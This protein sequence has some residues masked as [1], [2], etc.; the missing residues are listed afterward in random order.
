VRNGE[1]GSVVTLLCDSGE[2]YRSTHLDD[3][4]MEQRG[5]DTRAAEAAMERFFETGRLET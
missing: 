4:W 3:A 2:R 5:L 1:Q